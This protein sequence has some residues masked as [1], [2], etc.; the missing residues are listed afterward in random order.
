MLP[1]QIIS[2]Q[3]DHRKLPSKYVQNRISNS[4]EIAGGGWWL[5]Y[6]QSQFYVKPTLGAVRMSC[7]FEMKN[8]PV[9]LYLACYYL[10]MLNYGKCL[11]G[12][13]YNNI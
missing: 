3:D 13:L 4:S 9:F 10:L 8:P 11:N 2:I 12:K 6:M 7:G 1:G 5:W